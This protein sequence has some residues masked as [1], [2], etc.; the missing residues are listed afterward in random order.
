MGLMHFLLPSRLS[1][2]SARQLTRAYVTAGPEGMPAPTQ[3]QI[4]GGVLAIQRSVGDSGS[5][6]V[7]WSVSENGQ[8]ILATGTLIERPHPYHLLVELARGKVNQVR[9]MACDWECGGLVLPPHLADRI[10]WVGL[11]FART[12]CC[13]ESRPE[14]EALAEQ[15]LRDA[16]QLGEALVELYV[17]QVMAARHVQQPQFDTSMS[18]TMSSP[19]ATSELERSFL[20]AFNAVRVPFLWPEIES[21]EAQYN[22]DR[23]DAV[24]HWARERG[25][26]VIAGPVVDFSLQRTPEW[27]ALWKGDV[28]GL[29]NVILDYFEAGLQRYGGDVRVWQLTANANCPAVLGLEEDDTLWLTARMAELARQVD[30]QFQ[31]IAGIAQPWGEYLGRQDRAYSPFGFADMLL[32][33][34]VS[35]SMID[36]E[37]VTG[38]QHRGSLGRD[39]LETSRLLDLYSL[40]GVPLRVTLG[41]PSQSAPDAMADPAYPIDDGEVY[42]PASQAEWTRRLASLAAC[43]P[44]VV[45]VSWTNF[46]DAEPHQF[47]HASLVN[48]QGQPKP[49]LAVLTELRRKHLR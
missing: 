34:R 47:P 36:L 31:L 13:Q 7:P 30:A 16:V 45:G 41:C 14:V 11:E 15:T 32:R 12:V 33:S 28:Q 3:A 37:L 10:H 21:A 35:V 1:A 6:H 5:L 20:G 24:I 17:E 23:T 38:V 49:A 8:L 9:S 25:L 22:W 26:G 27:L 19:P 29:S 46:S 48:A 39:S 4:Q 18:C 2:E 44:F 42:S 40:L 43:K